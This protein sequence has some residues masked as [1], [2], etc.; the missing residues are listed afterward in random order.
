MYE[1]H[2]GKDGEA[3]ATNAATRSGGDGG[4]G[5]RGWTSR[6]ARGGR[7]EE[8]AALREEE[9]HARKDRVGLWE[10]GDVG[11]DDEDQPQGGGGAWGRRIASS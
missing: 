4:P 5:P 7:K 9:E 10:Y 1:H 11:S 2:G 8:V 3:R 6:P